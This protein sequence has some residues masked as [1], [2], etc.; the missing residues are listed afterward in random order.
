MYIHIHVLSSLNAQSKAARFLSLSLVCHSPSHYYSL[1][2][3]HP[4]ILLPS[5]SG[6]TLAHS[7]A[8]CFV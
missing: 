6:R 2:F 1:S 7:L 5:N 8:L 3:S 4:Y